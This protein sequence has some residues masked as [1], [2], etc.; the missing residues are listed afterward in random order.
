MLICDTLVEIAVSCDL[1]PV[2]FHEA[3]LDEWDVF[4]SGYS[5]RYA[6][7]LAQHPPDHPDAQ[8]LRDSLDML[9]VSESHITWSMRER[10]NVEKIKDIEKSLQKL[11]QS[12]HLATGHSGAGG[13]SPSPQRSSRVRPCSSRRRSASASASSL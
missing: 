4:E 3:S 9:R 11:P 10:A 8:P 7:W 1:M 6:T 13:S 5:A 2:A 12:I